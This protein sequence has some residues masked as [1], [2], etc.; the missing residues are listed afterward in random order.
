SS[1]KLAF[2]WGLLAGLA[3]WTHLLAI[4]YIAPAVVYLALGRRR[5]ALRTPG[6]GPPLVGLGALVGM[7]PLL[8]DNATNGFLTAKALLQPPD[9]P[10]DLVAQWLRFFRVGVPV[11]L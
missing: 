9:L 1:R 3:F 2:L 8:I 7:L 11:L 5:A 4:V 6:A 10:L